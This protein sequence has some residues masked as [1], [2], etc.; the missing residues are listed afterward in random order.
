MNANFSEPK[1]LFGNGQPGGNSMINL[2]SAKKKRIMG[3][4]LPFD[5]SDSKKATCFDLNLETVHEKVK[6]DKTLLNISDVKNRA[7]AFKSNSKLRG[8][9]NTDG[10]KKIVNGGIQL[11]SIPMPSMGERNEGVQLRAKKKSIAEYSNS[12]PRQL[13]SKSSFANVAQQ[14]LNTNGSE[15][16]GLTPK[17]S[18]LNSNIKYS[19][20]ASVAPS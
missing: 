1:S 10:V 20:L 13:D 5:Y 15:K 3:M 19:D 6:D 17:E 18:L 9:S 4:P 7:G 2:S 14:I 11:Q 8:S 16:T 12:K